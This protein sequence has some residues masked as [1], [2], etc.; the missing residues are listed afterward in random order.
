MLGLVNDPTS[1]LSQAVQPIRDSATPVTN[2]AFQDVLDHVPGAWFFARRNGTFAYFNRGACH[3]LGYSP[4][5]F[6]NVSIFDIDPTLTPEIW[7]ML[8]AETPPRES[9]TIRVRHRRKDGSSF[10]VEVRASRVLIDG[11]DLAVS[12]T[13]DLTASELTERMNRRLLAAIEQTSEAV[14]VTDALGLVE[15]VNPAYER[16]S[17]LRERAVRGQPWLQLEGRGDARLAEALAHVLTE[18]GTWQGRIRSYRGDGEA[19][20]EDVSLSP[21]RDDGSHLVGCVAVKRDVTEQLR[22]EQQLVQG[23]RIEAVGQLAGGIAHDF[24]NLLQVIQAQAQLIRMRTGTGECAPMLDEIGNAVA[25]ASNLVR[26]LL[27]FSRK[28]TIEFS[29]V[30]FEQLVSDTHQ[31]LKPLF[32]RQI[33]LAWQNTAGAVHVRG[34]APQLEQV[35]VNLCINARDAMPNGGVLRLALDRAPSPWPAPGAAA[36][37]GEAVV[38]SVSDSG[39]GMTD[40][41]QSRLFEPF[42]TTKQPGKG[43]GLGLA[44]VKSIVE[45]HAGSIDVQSRPGAGTTFR[46]FLPC[47]PAADLRAQP[48]RRNARID[49]AGRWVVVAEDEPGA[50]EASVAYLE[51]TGFRVLKAKDGIEADEL[52]RNP[53]Y[54]VRLAILDVVMPRW[55]GQAVL[56]AMRARG[57]ALPVVFVTGYD[58]ESLTA[59]VNQPG[60]AILQK[61]FSGEELLAM[62]AQV[63]QPEAAGSEQRATAD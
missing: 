62:V 51:R 52:L 63:L 41:I 5:E 42:F 55:S 59:V 12:Y 47:A 11:E 30:Q 25:R 19:F 58:Y 2:R 56:D 26:Q 14:V 6:K 8:W 44:T 60:I 22:I 61:P 10:P 36:S 54:D 34:N 53:A 46:V 17:G 18:A 37:S 4:A 45:A 38:L 23:K 50:I 29:E 40:E 28:G 39:V 31:M 3:S 49:G 48:E 35:V 33:E 15:Y 16:A 9:R 32:G 13:I 1:P 27:A 24:N 43:T 57:Q 21:L 7:R 20:D